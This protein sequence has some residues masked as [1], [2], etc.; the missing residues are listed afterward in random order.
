LAFGISQLGLA[1][2]QPIKRSL[3]FNFVV[4]GGG[5]GGFLFFVVVVVLFCFVCQLVN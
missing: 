3:Q 5:G 4:V 2:N 1:S